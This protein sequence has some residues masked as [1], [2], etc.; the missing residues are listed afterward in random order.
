MSGYDLGTYHV[1]VKFKDGRGFIMRWNT[2]RRY[3]HGMNDVTKLDAGLIPPHWKSEDDL[4]GTI[5][6]IFIDGNYSCDCN[7]AMFLANAEQEPD[8]D[9]DC[10]G[11]IV[12]DT[13]T[14]IRPDGTEQDIYP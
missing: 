7:L 10:G 2:G 4:F 11:T 5:R 12:V 8:P 14:A 9:L 6:Y 1:R 13:L 3:T